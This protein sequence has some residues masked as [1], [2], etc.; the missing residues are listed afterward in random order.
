MTAV[1]FLIEQFAIGLYILIGVGVVW[2]WRWF[3]ISR[4]QYR[5]TYFELERGLASY[6][7]ANAITAMILLAELALVVLGVQRVVAPTIRAQN[8]FAAEVLIRPS[9]GIFVTATGQVGL[10]EPIDSNLED[11]QARLEP[12]EIGIQVTPTLTPT[13]VGTI[14]PNTDPPIGCDTENAALQ[15]PANGMVVHEPI[16]VIGVANAENFAFYR[17]ELNGPSTFNNFAILQESPQ[18]VSERS[19][20]GQFVPSF[21]EPGE[22]QFRLTVF[23]ITNDLRDSCSVTIYISDPIPTPTPLSQE[24]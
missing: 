2:A 6:Q 11:V 23:D 17:F 13:P 9:D 14:L 19:S 7:R 18:P 3:R 21:Y 15:V 10:G 12:T 1:V 22:Y 24:S 5:E 16:D 8:E 4:R 20:L